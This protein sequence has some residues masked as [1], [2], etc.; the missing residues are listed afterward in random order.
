MQDAVILMNCIYDIEDVTHEN[1]KAALA[2]Y[3]AQRF[4]HALEQINLGKT[5]AKIMFGQVN[6]LIPVVPRTRAIFF[7]F[8]QFVLN[9]SFPLHGCKSIS[10]C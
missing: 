9:E 10:L 8:L 2:D 5:F 1:I 7:Y 3:K 4:E 6:V